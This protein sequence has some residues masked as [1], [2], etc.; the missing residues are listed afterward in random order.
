MTKYDYILWDF[1]GTILDDAAL[2]VQTENQ[3]RR[4]SGM[5]EISIDFF[6]EHMCFPI[7]DYYI[8]IGMDF[9]QISYA[10]MCVKFMA[11]FQPASLHAPFREGVIDFITAQS[12][13]GQKQILLSAA[14]KNNLLEQTAH[15][16]ITGLFEE[17]LGISDILGA[18]KIELALSWLESKEKKPERMLFIGDT[19]HDFEVS[20][21]L[22]CD[23]VLLTGGHSNR[24]RL[25]TAG[26]LVLDTIAELEAVCIGLPQ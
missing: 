12:K 8:N 11:I 3:L 6:R 2:C 4:E 24:K 9:T 5:P 1:N 15:F 10:D 22:G 13:K 17:V 25:E 21:A 7:K 19:L 16:G 23:C 20:Q 18:S 26:V 14:E